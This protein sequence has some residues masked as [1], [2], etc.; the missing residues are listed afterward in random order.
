MTNQTR[1]R[2]EKRIK[3]LEDRLEKIAP[4]RQL[5]LDIHIATVDAVRDEKQISEAWILS[6]FRR[7]MQ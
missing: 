4:Y 1:Y 6:Q 5:A 3:E 2:Y 7:V